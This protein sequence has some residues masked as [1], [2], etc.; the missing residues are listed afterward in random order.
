MQVF[1]NRVITGAA[2]K[3]IT[4]DV[5]CPDTSAPVSWLIYAHG[6]NGFKDW[7]NFDRIAGKIAEAGM[8]LVKFNFSH[9]GTTPEEPE[10]FTDLEAFGQNNYTKQLTDLKAVTDWICSNENP[11]RLL[12]D[13]QRLYLLGHSMGGTIALLYAAEDPR[14]RKL[15]TW[16][17]PSACKTPW[18]NWPATKMAEW[19][20]AGV[21]YHTN[22]RTGQQ[23]PLYYQLYRDYEAHKDRL[24]VEKAIRSLSVPVLIC[25]G[26]L[27]I[28][29]PPEA[30][31]QLHGWQPAAELFLVESNHVF[32]RKHPW[33]VTWLPPATEQVLEK[34]LR[35]LQQKTPVA[36][37]TGL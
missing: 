32:D 3:P 30:A 16:A 19:K 15:V 4:L 13:P 17:A 27:D 36:G 8:A 20:H 6:F 22:T 18:G 12:L 23:M 28:S 1:K 2:G 11:C 10:Q 37:A 9:N 14:I 21:Q 7:G 33:V 5:F 35:F 26:T 24:D 31:E 29:V 25:H 34:T